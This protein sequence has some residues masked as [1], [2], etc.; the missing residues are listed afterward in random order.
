M[1]TT[2]QNYSSSCVVD[3]FKNK[4]LV[5]KTFARKARVIGSPEY[6]F[7][8]EA[9]KENPGFK[10]VE[11][12]IKKSTT[13]KTYKGLTYENMRAYLEEWG[14]KDSD[15]V[16]QFEATLRLAKVQPA[17]YAYVKKW[18][19]DNYPDYTT[20]KSAAAKATTTA[21]VKSA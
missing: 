16:A 2:Q 3:V 21:L 4:I 13:K 7:F 12:T 18:F 10:V 15:A 8:T 11:K 17:Q 5:T 19:I 9:R 1:K 14:G 20:P 6:S